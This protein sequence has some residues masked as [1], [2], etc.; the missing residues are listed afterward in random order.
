MADS[1]PAL[2]WWETAP[3]SPGNLSRCETEFIVSGEPGT[4]M[5]ELTIVVAVG[6]SWTNVWSRP[7]FE[8]LRR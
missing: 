8:V 7:M 1:D 5:A 2:E 4:D 3:D 6:T